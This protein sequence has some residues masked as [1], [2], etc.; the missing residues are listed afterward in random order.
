MVDPTR[1]EMVGVPVTVTVSEK[2][3]VTRMESSAT[4]VLSA[5]AEEETESD[6][7]DAA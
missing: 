7:T 6:D 4:Y 3:T 5:P 1:T 2:L